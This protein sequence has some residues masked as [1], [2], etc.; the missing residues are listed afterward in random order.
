MTGPMY[1]HASPDIARHRRDLAPNQQAAFEAFG[2]AVFADG[3][4]SVKIKQ[5]I[6][7]AVAHVTQWAIRRPRS[8]LVRPR[9]NSWKR[10]GWRR[11]CGPAGAMRIRT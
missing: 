7:V 9:K 2:K 5:V 11:R 8:A 4:L 1:P 3:A 6:A 10:S